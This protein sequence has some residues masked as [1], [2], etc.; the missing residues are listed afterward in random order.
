MQNEITFNV[1]NKIALCFMQAEH[2]HKVIVSHVDSHGTKYQL[3]TIPPEEFVMLWNLYN[4][5]KCNDIQND[6]I[7]P[8]G[9]N[10]E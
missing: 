5:V 3:A 8:Y 1:N 2:D 7:N 6:F 9:K 4:Y 10:K